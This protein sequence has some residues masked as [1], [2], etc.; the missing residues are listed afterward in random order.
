[1]SNFFVSLHQSLHQEFLLLD[2]HSPNRER[3]R[4]FQR[5]FIKDTQL[6]ISFTSK[7]NLFT[8]LA[9]RREDSK[10][11]GSRGGNCSFLING[12]EGSTI[13]FKIIGLLYEVKVQHLLNYKTQYESL[14]CAKHSI[15]HR[16]MAIKNQFCEI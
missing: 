7:E 14:F 5:I 1:M 3:E 9:I 2:V 4:Q 6:G 10:A 15:P 8:H 16:N 11:V 13:V 12:C